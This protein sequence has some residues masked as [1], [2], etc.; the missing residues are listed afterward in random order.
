MFVNIPGDCHKEGNRVSQDF[1]RVNGLLE[2]IL[3]PGRGI[4]GKVREGKPW[5]YLV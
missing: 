4:R 5:L 3:L 1:W 2:A